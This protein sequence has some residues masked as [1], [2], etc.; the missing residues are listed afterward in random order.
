MPAPIPTASPALAE[1]LFDLHEGRIQS[2]EGCCRETAATLGAHT[3]RLDELGIKVDSAVVE[4]RGAV[5]SAVRPLAVAI[6]RIDTT[7]NE[8]ACRVD[9]LEE[10]RVER[11]ALLRAAEEKVKARRSKINALIWTAIGA[12][13]TVLVKDGLPRLISLLQ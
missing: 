13:L 9:T 11:A 6:S 2:L 8:N 5:D 1:H 4:I 7:I 12:F 10:N 3:E